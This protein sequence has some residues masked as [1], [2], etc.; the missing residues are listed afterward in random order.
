MVIK[1][2]SDDWDL[3]LVINQTVK[4]LRQKK[5]NPMIFVIGSNKKIVTFKQGFFDRLFEFK[6]NSQKNLIE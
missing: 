1:R 4:W 5:E 6:N 3:I 2:I